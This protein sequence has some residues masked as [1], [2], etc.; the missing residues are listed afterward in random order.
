VRAALREELEHL[1]DVSLSPDGRQLAFDMRRDGSDRV[2]IADRDGSHLRPLTGDGYST[3]QFTRDGRA[4][5]VRRAD[6][7]VFRLELDGAR[8]SP[9]HPAVTQPPTD[10]GPGGLVWVDSATSRVMRQARDGTIAELVAPDAAHPAI[11]ELSCDDAG[12]RLLYAACRWDQRD[13]Q[14]W[15][16]R[17]DDGKRERL[18]EGV[19]NVFAAR[20]GDRDAMLFAQGTIDQSHLWEAT[21]DGKRRRQLTFGGEHE[22]TARCARDGSF[23]FTSSHIVGAVFATR[24]GAPA[25]QLTY[26]LGDVARLIATPDP[27]TLVLERL[28]Q[29]RS[30]ATR[31]ALDS[32]E[33]TLLADDARPLQILGDELIYARASDGDSLELR[34]LPLGGGPARPWLSAH[35]DRPYVDGE[36]WLHYR[37]SSGAG[38]G[39]YAAMRV[40]PGGTPAAEAPAPWQLVMPAPVSGWRAA[41]RARQPSLALFAPGAS[42][43]APPTTELTISDAVSQP[44]AWSRDGRTLYYVGRGQRELRRHQVETNEDTPLLS[45]GSLDAFAVSSDGQ[46]LYHAENQQRA[47]IEEIENFAARPA[48]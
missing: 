27:G 43:S 48:L 39:P 3:P 9:L 30:R 17:L 13:A 24:A 32:G 35:G 38:C 2:W 26:E 25:R 45:A 16:V 40:R 10:C 1:T 19:A 21:L 28:R 18:L 41:L 23:I 15:L 14:V 47:R 37:A 8:L 4:L 20:F 46:T 36:G 42:L 33:E 29:G 11:Y 44:I 6:G 22:D 34:A 7:D 12:R 5:F 31:L